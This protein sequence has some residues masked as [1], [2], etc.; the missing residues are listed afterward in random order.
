M[1]KFIEDLKIGDVLSENI[2]NV[3]RSIIVKKGD[4]VT[5]RIINILKMWGIKEVNIKSVKTSKIKYNR[6]TS[7][8]NPDEHN[9]GVNKI[10]DI[11]LGTSKKIITERINFFEK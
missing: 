9:Y 6:I 5:E 10:M 11:V 8:S 4:S 7:D 3:N 1:I 2:S